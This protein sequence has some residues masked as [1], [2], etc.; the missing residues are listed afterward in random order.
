MWRHVELLLHRAE[1]RRAHA[2]IAV[3]Q[4]LPVELVRVLLG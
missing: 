2:G 1:L 4:Q 3:R